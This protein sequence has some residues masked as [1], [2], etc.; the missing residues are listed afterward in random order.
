M[1][2]EVGCLSGFAVLFIKNIGSVESEYTQYGN[3]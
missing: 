2:F 3:P 1:K